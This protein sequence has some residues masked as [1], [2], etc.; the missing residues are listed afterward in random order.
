M[1]LVVC[2]EQT[3]IGSETPLMDVPVR[4]ARKM[5]GKIPVDCQR[6]LYC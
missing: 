5:R 1:A 4:Q 2:N 6:L 3:R